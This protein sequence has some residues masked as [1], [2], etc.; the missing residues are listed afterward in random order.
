MLPCGPQAPSAGCCRRNKQKGSPDF[1][2]SRRPNGRSQQPA[3]AVFCVKIILGLPLTQSFSTGGP[4][5]FSG[6]IEVVVWRSPAKDCEAQWWESPYLFFTRHSRD[7]VFT[8]FGS[9]HVLKQETCSQHWWSPTQ[10]E[11]GEGAHT[12]G[13]HFGVR[14]Q[15][16]FPQLP[17]TP[18]QLVATERRLG[19]KHIIAVDPTI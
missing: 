3:R 1:P 10:E 18:R 8:L 12:H 16:V 13:L 6:S 2:T 19:P 7:W 11:G 9:F 5:L 4:S 14:L 15:P 17:A